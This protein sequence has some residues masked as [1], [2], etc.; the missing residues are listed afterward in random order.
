MK[1]GF[2]S[3]KNV[4]IFILV[5]VFFSSFVFAA[6][7][8]DVAGNSSGQTGFVNN[9]LTL[10]AN[11]L[12][13]N[14]T[15]FTINASNLLINGG[16]FNISSNGSGTG[17]SDVGGFDNVTI[18]NFAG[19]LNFTHGINLSSVENATIFN[20][21][22][23]NANAANGYGIYLK[24]NANYNNIS[25]NTINTSG[26]NGYGIYIDTITQRNIILSNNIN[27]SGATAYG[28]LLDNSK[29]QIVSGN[30]INTFNTDGYG[31][32]LSGSP[33]GNNVTGNVITTRGTTAYPVVLS[34]PRVYNNISDN[35]LTSHA[36]TVHGVFFNNAHNQT[37]SGNR[38]ETNGS[39]AVGVRLLTSNPENNTIQLNTIITNGTSAF[40]I[41][42][43]NPITVT[44]RFL[45]NRINTSGT[46]AYGI[47]L[48]NSKEQ[49]V[50]GNTINTFN[51]DGYGIYLEGS[52]PSGNNVTG[53]V[54]TTRG[55][56]A[57][58]VVLS[59]PRVY[60]NISDNNLTSHANTV[61]G[62]FFNNAH[63][64]TFSGNRIET[65]G[66][67]AEGVHLITSN[68][69]NN[70]ISRNTIITNG[71]DAYGI[72]SSTITV[73]NRFLSNKIN[74]SGAA[75][76]GI[77]LSSSDFHV[78]NGNIINV[79]G[80]GAD[81]RGID[82]RTADSN[83]VTGN[84]VTMFGSGTGDI[85][86]FGIVPNGGAQYNN[87]SDNNVTT[88]GN[89]DHGILLHNSPNN[90]VSGNHIETNG[91]TSYGIY[92]AS[93]SVENIT[94]SSN[95]II[96]N[97]TD[98]YGIYSPSITATNRFLSNNINTS[99][100]TAYGIYLSGSNNHVLESNSITT[101]SATNAYAIFLDNA[102][103]NNLTGDKL[104]ATNSAEF[105]S[106]STST[107]NR[108]LNMILL[109]DVN[110]TSF[111]FNAVQFD[112]N[113]TPPTHSVLLGN[114][115]DF[116]DISQTSAG[117]YI[118]FN[119][120]YTANDVN[121]VIEN[122]IKMFRFNSTSNAYE[123]I[124]TFSLDTTNNIVRS[125]NV[126]SFS[127]FTALGDLICAS[128]NG[129]ITLDKNLN[130]ING[131]CMTINA[132]NII[133]EGAG[134]NLT[135]NTTGMGFFSNS[136]FTNITIRN[137]G[138]INNFTM[139]INFTGVTGSTI[140]NNTII[141]ADVANAYG[142]LLD[143]KSNNNNISNNFINTSGTESSGIRLFN[144]FNNTIVSNKLNLSGTNGAIT[145][146]ATSANNNVSYNVMLTVGAGGTYGIH[147]A[148]ANNN[149]LAF[150]NVT[151]TGGTAHG[152]FFS[153][154]SHNNSI[155][156]NIVNTTGSSSDGMQFSTSN[157]NTILLNNI[158]TTS[159]SADGI[160]LLSNADFNNITANTIT[161]SGDSSN[162]IILS[163]GDNDNT[164]RLNNITT[165][166]ALARGISIASSVRNN[167][168][169]N[170]IKTNHSTSDGIFISS[171]S[172]NNKFVNDQVNATNSSEIFV[173]SSS[174]TVLSNVLLL[175]LS[176]FSSELIENVSV[177]VNLTPSA[178]ENRKNLSD[179]FI[180]NTTGGNSIINFNVSYDSSETIGIIES[181]IRIFRFNETSNQY[182]SLSA[183]SV[184]TTNNF[185]SSGNITSFSLFASLGQFI[186]SA[187]S[188]G[189]TMDQN[190]TNVNGTCISVN[191]SNI[192]IN[193]GGFMISGNGSGIGMGVNNTAG[194]DNVTIRNFVNILNFSA[195]F[196]F[197]NSENSTIFNNTIISANAANSRGIQLQNSNLTNITSNN[198]NTSNTN[199]QGILLL[200]SY[201]NTIFSNIINTSGIGSYGLIFNSSSNS[202]NISSNLI[203]TTGENSS[204]IFVQSSNSSNFS[205]NI[206]I[207]SHSIG[208]YGIFL[209]TADNNSFTAEQVNASGS[210]E[211]FVRT[212]FTVKNSFKNIILLGDPNFTTSD[213]AG[214]SINVNT[215][216]P[217]STRK[218]LSDFLT[219][220]ST[221]TGGFI[222]FNLSYTSADIIGI[223]EANLRMFKYNETTLV[224]D[225]L[226]SSS[227]DIVNNVVS[228]GNITSF[229]LFAPLENIIAAAGGGEEKVAPKIAQ[230][231][232]IANLIGE[233]AAV[234]VQTGKQI[235]TVLI[236]KE[237]FDKAKFPFYLNDKS[238]HSIV[239]EK[240]DV[241][242]QKAVLTLS[243]NPITVNM[244]AGD[245]KKFDL[246]EN[247]YYDTGLLLE[248]VLE[249][250]KGVTV[251]I[252]PLE[253]SERVK[254]ESREKIVKEAVKEPEFK[255]EQF[256]NL[257][258][259]NIVKEL[260]AVSAG[261]LAK[262]KS[263]LKIAEFYM[264]ELSEFID[265]YV[266]VYFNKYTNYL[267]NN[268]AKSIIFVALSFILVITSVI[269]IHNKKKPPKPKSGLRYLLNK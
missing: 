249:S 52:G 194:F 265:K 229:S 33:S 77:F 259:G 239:V 144:S 227:V 176:N 156:S 56:T 231:D 235:R 237:V 132:S 212:A 63:N 61:H 129:N 198:I 183:S 80:S 238:L 24:S 217:L 228:S 94:I 253:E 93:S 136:S 215:T 18:R 193:G 13:I 181:T 20:N 135:G 192:V 21:T 133:L 73:T 260:G 131:T 210:E 141:G 117:G 191:A 86:N 2:M 158:T 102:D 78:V 16:G 175:S 60:N 174:S 225:L 218:N 219:I 17:L 209:D 188:E 222:N 107:D 167:F 123:N 44:N 118:D 92:L 11:I 251:L 99:G 48:P 138:G 55:T 242:N 223:V 170:I 85:T 168:S 19:I 149:T 169:A 5:A 142:I 125:G 180:I 216:P 81:N 72:L 232:L 214:V 54:I 74:T 87:V 204:G 65:N 4:L 221:A 14:G 66:S 39:S 230:G 130:N 166:G 162:G 114:L 254:K 178:H 137:F 8:A 189:F 9:D 182:E 68:P 160:D 23:S 120:S 75:A 185:I 241:L 46:T 98:S 200:T 22:I 45:S 161:T 89:N 220:N 49:V 70:T 121:Q 69:E 164:V 243:S 247:G 104:N 84:I 25:S 100:S 261:W 155:Q 236:S 112:I 91:S 36:N 116:I 1:K 207:T 124:T 28:I 109:G 146:S 101:T 38:I 203:N 26:S 264:K 150:N 126:T 206:I 179:F 127:I 41:E 163:S 10:T 103:N 59:T 29:E 154:N 208:A 35:N 256:N 71:T 57:Y 248:N 197:S 252:T 79:F 122:T 140:F 119:L 269:I 177:N 148:T 7:C 199:S 244:K 42:L 128:R 15:C 173:L 134:F 113:T 58:P 95:T 64:Q 115:T 147:L 139:G 196:N 96:T 172:D 263:M 153:S 106:I 268:L 110:I 108:I 234:T 34:T 62:V 12:N 195:G 143:A 190:F 159:T 97:G 76:Y 50:S 151:T 145:M 246:N 67:S 152:I 88:H 211:I 157:N 171:T 53:N 105:R 37:F 213:I 165:Q 240:V 186:C 30:T 187:W 3:T 267:D 90:T 201:S 250:G 205:N 202:N 255:A 47:Y 233:V 82:I 262:L 257:I 31:I 111:E 6:N 258:T 184:D 245:A 266:L 226:S 224:Y 43:V 83:N 27:T 40:G 51:T 32:Y